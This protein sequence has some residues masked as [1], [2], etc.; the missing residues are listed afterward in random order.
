MIL[1]Q[2]IT[3]LAPI[4]KTK[5]SFATETLRKPS[6]T[7]ERRKLKTIRKPQGNRKKTVHLLQ[8][9][10]NRPIPAI[11]PQ[12]NWYP[13]PSP[14]MKN[15]VKHWW[16][17]GTESIVLLLF[18]VTIPVLQQ[19]LRAIVP[20]IVDFPAPAMPLSQKMHLSSLPSRLRVYLLEES[21]T[22]IVE[23]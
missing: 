3:S 22:H 6:Q 4:L 10:G 8:P 20:A 11:V 18:L 13:N 1:F 19:G 9:S 5:G 15:T 16:F 2:E 14:T 21:D 23:T 17:S 7:C 12:R